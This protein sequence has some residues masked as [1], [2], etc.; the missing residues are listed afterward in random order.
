MLIIIK[1]GKIAQTLSNK[2][3]CL[4]LFINNISLYLLRILKIV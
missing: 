4:K 1:L 2:P 3:E